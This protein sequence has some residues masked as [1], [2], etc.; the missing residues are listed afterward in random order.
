MRQYFFLLL[1]LA[2]LVTAGC[3]EEYPPETNVTTAQTPVI[4]TVP[5]NTPAPTPRPVPAEMGYLSN[6]KCGIGDKTKDTYHCNGDVRIRSGASHEVQVVARYADNN[7]FYSGI[8]D[9]GGSNPTSYPFAIF[10]DLKYKGQNPD[11]FVKLDKILYPV[12]WSGNYG[13]AW[14]NRS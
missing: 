11:Y 8:F 7:S 12:F 13:V 9:L 5:V 10:P 14:S 4:T 3:V 2:V 1:V 6:I